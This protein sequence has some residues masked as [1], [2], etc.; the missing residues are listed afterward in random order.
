MAS[1][2]QIENF[3]KNKKIAVAGASINPNK[4]SN[5]IVKELI[6]KGYQVY[7]VNP[8]GGE[9][10][11]RKVYHNIS[12]LPTDVESVYILTNKSR[13]KDILTESINNNKK[14]IWIHQS[15]D[16]DYNVSSEINL[17]MGYCIIMFINAKGPHMIHKFFSKITGK[18]PK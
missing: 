7:P 2:I 11:S 14:N 10:H 15:I 1:I 9:I 18:Y 13:A 3:L 16:I 17:I 6:D 12:E 5:N 8:K 4:L